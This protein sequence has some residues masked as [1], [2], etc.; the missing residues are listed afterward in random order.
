MEPEDF[1]SYVFPD[2]AGAAGPEDYGEGPWRFLAIV[3]V[4]E[5][6]VGWPAANSQLY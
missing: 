6:A 3:Q 1:I 2:V 5:V 4:K